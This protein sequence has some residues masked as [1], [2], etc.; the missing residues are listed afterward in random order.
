MNSDPIRF[1]HIGLVHRLFSAKKDDKELRYLFKSYL[2]EK[3]NLL[4]DFQLLI[5]DLQICALPLAQH[6]FLFNNKNY[7]TT[8]R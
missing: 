2:V 5:V 6:G 8:G 7:V 1:S 3:E 4:L